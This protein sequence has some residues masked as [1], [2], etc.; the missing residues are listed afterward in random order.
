MQFLWAS[1]EINSRA[2]EYWSIVIDIARKFNVT[3]MK[4]CGQIMGR[5]EGDDIPTSQILY[6]AMQCADIF[7]LKADVCQLGLDQ[8]KVNVLAKEYCD[9]I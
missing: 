3:R 5:K 4:K 7:F 1:D 2:D 9:L 8:R 6:P